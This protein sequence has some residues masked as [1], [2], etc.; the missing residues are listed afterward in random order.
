MSFRNK[1]AFCL[2]ID[3]TDWGE[4]YN[5]TDTQEAFTKFHSVQTTVYTKHFPKI[6]VLSKYNDRKPWL[7]QGLKN[8][9]KIK[10]KLYVR[11]I[12]MNTAQH[13]MQYKY[14]RNKL[15]HILRIAARKHYTYLLN[16]NKSNL[17]KTW[18]IMKGI[19]NKN[20][21]NSVNARL[22]LQDGSLTT[23]KQLTSERFNDFFVGIG[24]SLAKKIPP[25][26]VSPSKFMAAK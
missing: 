25:Q 7:S 8:S 2:A 20:R 22:K 10:K 18:K 6:T 26:N 11:Y 24:P 13:E 15:N 14:Y 3:E 16:N 17:K 23:D 5:T 21:S 12:E 1:E 9:I 19:I 4:I